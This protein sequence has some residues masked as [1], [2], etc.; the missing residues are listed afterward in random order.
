LKSHISFHLSICHLKFEWF[1][2]EH[3]SFLLQ[4]TCFLH[5]T[6]SCFSNLFTSLIKTILYTWQTWKPVQHYILWAG[7]QTGTFLYVHR[8][9]LFGNQHKFR[10]VTLYAFW[11]F[12]FNKLHCTMVSCKGNK[13]A[14]T[15]THVIEHFEVKA[16]SRK[17]I[18]C[19]WLDS[20]QWYDDNHNIMILWCSCL[21]IIWEHSLNKYTDICPP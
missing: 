21:N 13:V 4:T 18:Y 19:Q 6:K 2:Y 5:W 16:F 17:Q 1:C 8:L 12:G 14:V 10:H 20:V 11:E 3:Y 9:V 7:Q 15:S